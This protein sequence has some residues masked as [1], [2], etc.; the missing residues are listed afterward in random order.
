M[1]VVAQENLVIYLEEL[2]VACNL[3]KKLRKFVG[4]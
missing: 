2:L 4:A 3:S 1:L